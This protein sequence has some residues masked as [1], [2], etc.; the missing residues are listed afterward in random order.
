MDGYKYLI[1]RNRLMMNLEEELE[2]IKMLPDEERQREKAR[3]EAE[4]DRA[5]GELYSQVADE[6]PGERRGKAGA[7]E[8]SR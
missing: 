8:D 3:L 7:T 2:K 1:Q 6:Y 4:F 5:L